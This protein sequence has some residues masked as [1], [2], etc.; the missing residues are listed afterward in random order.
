MSSQG[1]GNAPGIDCEILLTAWGDWARVDATL[2]SRI[3]GTMHD[4]LT[5]RGFGDFFTD[6]T[7]CIVDRLIASLPSAQKRVI[8]GY[9]LH[10]RK[11]LGARE[12]QLF[13][14][15]INAFADSLDGGALDGGQK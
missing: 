3:R 13:R 15:A 9:Y 4:G 7:M 14:I 5:A 12:E 11:E 1:T 2:A 10:K 8:K 6:D